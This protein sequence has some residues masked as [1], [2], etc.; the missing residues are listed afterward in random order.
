[1]KKYKDPF[2]TT[3]LV[4]DIYFKY[5]K[6]FKKMTIDNTIACIEVKKTEG[7]RFPAT[8]GARKVSVFVN[9]SLWVAI[10]YLGTESQKVQVWPLQG[11]NAPKTVGLT[12]GTLTV[13]RYF[14]HTSYPE[15]IQLAD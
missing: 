15:V 10:G 13:L 12:P 1:M 11:N 4:T 6:L 7:N 3:G 8:E 14:D 9:D 2:T 5:L